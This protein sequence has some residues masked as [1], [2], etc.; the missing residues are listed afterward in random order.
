MNL[1]IKHR[2]AGLAILAAILP[3]LIICVLTLIQKNSAQDKVVQEMEILAKENITQ[4]AQDVYNLLETANDLVQL[5]VDSN[6]KVAR[7]VMSQLGQVEFSTERIQWNAKNQY[8]SSSSLVTLPGMSIGRRIIR[9][10]KDLSL[11]SPV[12]DRVEE[13]VGGTCTIFQK[14]NSNGDML[15]IATNVRKL[16]NTRAV[17]T[18]IPAVNPD[19]TKNPVISTVMR[20]QTFRGRA[21][22]VNAW[23]ITAYEPIKDSRGE[24]V[25][26]LYVGVKQESVESLRHAIINTKVGKTGYV[27]ILGGKGAHKGSYIVSKGGARDGESIWEAKDTD[28][29]YFIQDIISKAVSLRS[30]EAGYETYPWL[31]K[32]EE[33]ARNKVV[34][35]RYFEPWDWVIG[36]GTYE[37]DYFEAKN[38]V[39][40]SLNSLLL[41]L[42]I[43][44]SGIMIAMAF[45]AIVTG[46]RISDP[47]SKMAETAV[48]LSSGDLDQNIDYRSKD[49]TGLLA[50]SFRK[51]ISS[52]KAKSMV[53]KDISKGKLDVDIDV[54]SEK[55]TLGKSM[56]AMRNG[57]INAD[58]LK[59]KVEDFQQVEVEKLSKLL[60]NMGNGDLTINYEVAEPDDDTQNVFNA[61]IKIKSGL[62]KTLSSMNDL[63]GQVNCSVDQ[64][65]AGATQVSDSSQSLSQGATQQASSLEETSASITEISSQTK[66]NAENADQANR[67]SSDARKIAD[68]GNDQMKIMVEAMTEIN[69][70]SNEISKII[71]VIDEIAFQTNLLALN[72]AVEAARAGV[73]GKGFAVV[74]EEVRSLAQRSSDAAKE[75]TELIKDSVR[76]VENGSEI[77]G[78]TAKS[79]EEIVIGITKVSEIVDDIAHASSEQSQGIG[80]INSALDQ[81]DQVTQSNTAN[82]EQGAAASEELSNQAVELKRMVSKFRLK[83]SDHLTAEADHNGITSLINDNGHTIKE[84]EINPTDSISKNNKIDLNDSC[85]ID[86]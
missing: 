30:G 13:L 46:N 8:T 35:I 32:G 74:A 40:A 69:N 79:L 72:A 51:M 17:G 78:E 83:E 12:V 36:A 18:F 5:T 66:A 39:E 2:I 41:W 61:F 84:N 49:E 27:Y 25:G 19:G 50:D 38:K 3:T 44:G 7:E 58:N 22:V 76:N 15:R 33:K 42:I 67:L 6:L 68:R 29:R 64:V 9:P 77:A 65:T 20:G 52:L 53:A 62:D 57:L 86:F 70:S 23:Y 48:L 10:N 43:G 81:I 73:H 80:Q 56:V 4:V 82:A 31:N 21:F 24:V 47:I 75:T 60:D 16:D 85:F 59:R 26:I 28:G 45:V 63:L 54:Q 1:M 34:A 14:M 11:I 71:K 55:D 37:D